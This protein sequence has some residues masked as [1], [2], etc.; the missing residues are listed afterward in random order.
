M[1]IRSL[2]LIL[3]LGLMMQARSQEIDRGPEGIVAAKRSVAHLVSADSLS[4]RLTDLSQLVAGQGKSVEKI[5]AASSSPGNAVTSSPGSSIKVGILV[6]MHG[7]ALQDTTSARQD[8][9][10]GFTPH[11]QRQLYLRRLRVILSGQLGNG[12]S[13]FFESDAANIGKAE[14]N[15][16]KAGTVQMYVQDAYMQHT[17]MPELSVIAGLQLVGTTRNSLQSAAT[18]MALNYGTY[19]FVASNVLDNNVGRDLGVNL[20]G[21]LFDE[22]LEYRA[23]VFSGKCLTLYSPLRTTARLSYMFEDRERGFFYTGTTLGKGKL[24]ALG[25]GFDAQGTYRGYSVD[26]FADRP[27]AGAGSLTASASMTLLNGGGSDVDSTYF[28]GTLPK[29]TIFFSEV[30]YYIT[31]LKLQPYVKYESRSVNATVLKQV[32]ATPTT[33]GLANALRSEHRLGIGC[34]YYFSEYGASVKLLFELVTRHRLSLDAS[35]A[36][37][38]TNGE[39]TVQFQ[40]FSL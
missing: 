14:T 31:D 19:Q 35:H 23:G 17:F 33:L 1:R 24:L 13:C 11:W 21:F 16:T 5:N 28:T 15:G 26:A 2:P 8:A 36:E 4:A 27:L 20:R 12:T 10:G 6:Q 9:S 38:A 37:S 30:G 39:C 25:A 32:R 40:Y 3:F 18:L 29:Q 7:Q 22:R 34:N